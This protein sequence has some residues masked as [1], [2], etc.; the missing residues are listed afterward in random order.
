MMMMMM[1]IMMMIIII[2][3]IIII[4]IIIMA[5]TLA[6]LFSGPVLVQAMCV[7]SLSFLS[8]HSVQLESALLSS[9]PVQIF[10]L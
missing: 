3:I 10:G 4:V 5:V 6:S 7:A 9:I 8:E 1:M 2:I